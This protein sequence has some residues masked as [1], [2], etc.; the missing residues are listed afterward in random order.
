[1]VLATLLLVLI[2]TSVVKGDPPPGHVV[3]FPDPIL[4]A[5]I[6]EAIGKPSGDILQSDLDGLTS[7]SNFGGMANLTG[8]EHCTNLTHL[9]LG[10]NNQISDLDLSPLSGLTNLTGLLLIGNNISNIS[11]LAGLTNLGGLDLTRNQI[12]DISPLVGLTNLFYLT[13]DENRIS[14]LE[15]LVHNPGLGPGGSDVIQVFHNPLSMASTNTWIPVLQG[16]GVKVFWHSVGTA[17]STGMATLDFEAGSPARYQR[18]SAVPES[19]IPSQGKPSLQF[20]HG[21]FEFQITDLSGPSVTLTI[22]L[23]SAV[24]TTAQYWK[25]GP[26][27]SNHTP[28]WYQIAMGDNDGDNVITITL[29]DGGLGDDDLTANGVIVDQ[30]G[31]GWPGPSGG[32]GGGHSAP[33][34]PSV[35]VGIGA[36]LGAGILAYALRKR[37]ATHRPE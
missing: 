16:R 2:P 6:R 13:L 9:L 8:M 23:P 17:T 19:S 1:M 5:G 14:N 4:Q 32:G 18:L 3:T 7:Y 12:T 25:Y 22:T 29:T 10:G 34:F 30:G 20:P 26:T 15:P 21:F 24:P 31:P 35:Y 36:A 11:P 28:H 33:V 27:P 37:L